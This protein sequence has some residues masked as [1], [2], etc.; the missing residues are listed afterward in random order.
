MTDMLTRELRNRDDRCAYLERL[1]R[2]LV[3]LAYDRGATKRDVESA[4]HRAR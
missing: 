4:I 1:A 3:K 2:E